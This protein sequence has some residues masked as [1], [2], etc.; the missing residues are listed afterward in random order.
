MCARRPAGA[1][2]ATAR[3]RRCAGPGSACPD[4]GITP[5]RLRST[6]PSRH[7]PCHSEVEEAPEKQAS[8][9]FKGALFHRW[10]TSWPL[11]VM[12]SKDASVDIREAR[13]NRI[14]VS[15]SCSFRDLSGFPCPHA[16]CLLLLGQGLHSGRCEPARRR[17]HTSHRPD[18]R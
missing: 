18:H 13:C 1:R 8:H 16:G 3:T 10:S 17:H 5:P 14:W 4:I 11:P 2:S 7:V 15:S 12:S 6:A 9:T